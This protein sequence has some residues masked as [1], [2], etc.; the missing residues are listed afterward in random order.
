MPNW[1]IENNFKTVLRQNQDLKKK[2]TSKK[3]HWSFAYFKM[4]L[5]Q[6]PFCIVTWITWFLD[7]LHWS[8]CSCNLLLRFRKVYSWSGNW[9]LVLM[10]VNIKDDWTRIEFSQY[11][12]ESTIVTRQISSVSG[13]TKAC[14]SHPI[15]VLLIA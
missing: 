8:P 11:L 4:S 7:K 15:I 2:A 14:D 3:G 6:T 13:E 12:H 9:M 1:L 5:K 10:Y